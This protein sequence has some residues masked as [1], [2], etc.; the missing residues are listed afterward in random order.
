MFPIISIITPS[1]NQGA[2][3]ED[4]IKS[5][6]SQEGDFEI[7]YIIVDG[8]SSDDSLEI[9]KKYDRLICERHF[10]PGCRRIRYRW[11]SEKDTGQSNAIN[12]GFRL[13]EG[14]IAAWLN[15]DDYYLPGAF[16]HAV[17]AFQLNSGLAFVYGSG[18]ISDIS[19][20]PTAGF[21]IEPLFDIW[22]LIHL[23]D[24]ILQPSAF[25]NIRAIKQAGYLDENLHYIMDWEFWIRLSRFGK[26]AYI[27]ED[28]SVARIYPEAKTQASGIARWKEIRNVSGKYGQTK[29][30]PVVFT[31]LF[32]RPLNLL[33]GGPGGWKLPGLSPLIKTVR[34]AYYQIIGGNSSGVD[35]DGSAGPTAYL[36]IP[37]REEIKTIEI[38][39]KA[40]FPV[41]VRWR[42]GK[43][44]SGE[45]S[46]KT[47]AVLKAPINSEM[48]KQGFVHI[49]FTSAN[50]RKRSF[51]IKEI[52]LFDDDNQQVTD[53]GLPQFGSGKLQPSVQQPE[54]L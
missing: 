45:V 1:F 18:K 42:A 20:K 41:R 9:I 23:Y 26:V 6:I 51:M 10:K 48:K 11:A 47:E 19:G 39:M 2:F 28:L 15:S 31:Q 49:E 33:A 37:V 44:C 34:R 12:K 29:Y 5:V 4:C 54:P 25:M 50:Q 43:C 24:F 7:D 17:R 21:P 32:H 53:V 35:F 14:E 8:G 13:A 40:F 46:L 36:S 3:I 27:P 38:R 22:K 52:L 16:A 30:P